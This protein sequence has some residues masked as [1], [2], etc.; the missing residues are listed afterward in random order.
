MPSIKIKGLQDLI[1]I[2]ESEARA[3][4]IKINSGELQPNSIITAGSF[5]GELRQV[6]ALFV[7]AEQQKEK[8]YERHEVLQFEIELENVLAKPL[9]KP[10]EFYGGLTSTGKYVVNRLM[11]IREPQIIEYCF[12]NK[13]IVKKEVN[14]LVYWCVVDNK[15]QEM[16]DFKRKYSALQDLKRHRKFA[17]QQEDE[18][19]PELI[20][21]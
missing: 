17:Q 10:A 14:N 21:F 8:E 16:M 9:S 12:D 2:P 4:R 20:P 19:K 15:I 1:Q 7:D 6:V 13:W 18:I 3:L 11:G 5:T